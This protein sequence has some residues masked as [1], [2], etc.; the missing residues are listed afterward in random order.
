[1]KNIY[2]LLLNLRSKAFMAGLLPLFVLTQ[3]YAQVK[4]SLRAKIVDAEGLEVYAGSVVVSSGSDSTLVATSFW[5][6]GILDMRLD[7]QYPVLL[8]LS[9]VGHAAKI[10]P[11]NAAQL[12][13]HG[14][15]D[16]GTIV[17]Q[18]DKLLK[19]VVI[20]GKKQMIRMSADKIVFN[21]AES[22][23][24]IG[25]TADEVLKKS[26]Q[27]I[28]NS[29]GSAAVAGKGKANI[30]LDGVLISQEMLASI[31]SGNIA[32]V[33]I[34]RNPS[35]RYDAAG[36]AVINLV[37]KKNNLFSSYLYIDE[38]LTRGRKWRQST[39]VQAGVKKQIWNADVKYRYYPS[40]IQ[41]EDRF[42]R[43]IILPGDTLNL[44]QEVIKNRSVGNR[45]SF[46]LATGL[47]LGKTLSLKAGYTA[48]F[49]KGK[50]DDEGFNQGTNPSGASNLL[51]HNLTDS[52]FSNRSHLLNYGLSFTPGKKGDQL[53]VSANHTW[54]DY[55]KNDAIAEEYSTNGQLSQTQKKNENHN[56]IVLSTV[57]ADYT[58]HLAKQI[59]VELG[60]KMSSSS[61][62][63][64]LIFSRWVQGQ[65]LRDVEEYNDYRYKEKIY[66]AYGDLNVGLGEFTV[67]AGLRME[68][69]DAKGLS[70]VNGRTIT[71]QS[72]TNFFPSLTLEHALLKELDFNLVYQKRI[73]RAKYQ[74]LNPYR[75]YIDS[76][77]VFSGN[78]LLRPETAN[79]FEAGL[80][81]KKMASLKVGYTR[82]K[83]AIQTVIRQQD[84]NSLVTLATMEN[85][86]RVNALNVTLSLPYQVGPWTTYNMI[87]YT[88][89]T[90]SATITNT[91]YDLSKPFWVFYTFNQ[92]N[93]PANFQ[94]EL[95]GTY[96]TS[97]IMGIFEFRPRFNLG[98]SIKKEVVKNKWIVSLA[99]NDIFNRDIVR[100]STSL[101]HFDL[102]YRGFEDSQYVRL[103]VSYKIGKSWK[104]NKNNGLDERIKKGEQ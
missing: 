15:L 59:N 10:V 4:K 88:R 36:A 81:Y 21:V 102:K 18:G 54:Y 64:S 101:N 8:K 100:T 80:T 74:D 79:Y 34:I 72:Y 7:V 91:L 60:G 23:L 53:S 24:A 17:M 55:A 50:G 29:D 67:Q 40:R 95:T 87:S 82:T 26:P 28:I 11:L 2:F 103:S 94:L 56:D 52:R 39:G 90:V 85:L 70:N 65:W 97:G 35:A 77:S 68:N 76:L 69:T 57:M 96:N 71:D 47:R 14:I 48:M 84:E 92:F 6:N 86:S 13:D 41:Q 1:M 22:G 25:G 49:S 61:N 27:V 3:G 46:D 19:E 58:L 31:P 62:N 66:A 43:T 99:G 45:H 33:E 78:P 63:S 38:S 16:L 44:Q 42:D 89:N 5:E 104:N 32:Q 93:L 83:D 37:T 9:A 98:A 51:L 75:L 30:Y 73:N 20:S 12:A